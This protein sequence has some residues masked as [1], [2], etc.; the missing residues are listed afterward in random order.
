MNG[1]MGGLKP[2]YEETQFLARKSIISGDFKMKLPKLARALGWLQAG[3]VIDRSIRFGRD[4]Q[5][6]KLK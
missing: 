2:K 3:F 5:R 1:L 4:F 6:S